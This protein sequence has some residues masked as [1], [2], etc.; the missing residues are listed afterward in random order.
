M[1]RTGTARSIWVV[2]IVEAAVIAAILA[3]SQVGAQDVDPLVEAFDDPTYLARA[4]DE[5][6]ANTV[7]DC[8]GTRGFEYRVDENA[9][10][11]LEEFDVQQQLVPRFE[12][13]LTES[14]PRVIDSSAFDS[15]LIDPGLAQPDAVAIPDLSVV[16]IDPALA[17]A[18]ELVLVVEPEPEFADP[19]LV[20]EPAVDGYGLALQTFELVAPDP[21]IEIVSALDSIDRDSYETALY[22]TPLAE[23]KAPTPIGGCALEVERLLVTEIVP[24]ITQLETE[25]IDFADQIESDSDYASAVASWSDCM[26]DSDVGQTLE[27]SSPDDAVALATDRFEGLSPGDNAAFALFTSFQTALAQADY[28]CRAVTTDLAITSILLRSGG[29]LAV[30]VLEAGAIISGGN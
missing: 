30:D 25:S 6:I 5:R 8:M 16:D 17:L 26:S 18:P 10:F 15:V 14:I 21:N 3:P 1:T 7:R 2:L 22:G 23:I 27:L 29:P 20:I 4:I 13:R 28:G 24:E 11:N 19:S 12:L 9:R